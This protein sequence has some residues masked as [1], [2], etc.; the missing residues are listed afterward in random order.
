MSNIDR[1]LRETLRDVAEG[2]PNR[3]A[4][5]IPAVRARAGQLR[6]LRLVSVALPLIM[7]I[8]AATTI[9]AKQFGDTSPVTATP[10]ATHSPSAEPDAKSSGADMTQ[11]PTIEPSGSVQVLTPTSRH[12]ALSWGLAVHP[13]VRGD[14]PLVGTPPR[15]VVECGV[16]VLG[17][18]QSGT[19]ELYAWVKCLEFYDEGAGIRNGVGFSSSA[20]IH[21]TGTGAS[22]SIIKVDFPRQANLKKDIKRLFPPDMHE[23]LIAGHIPVSP[24][25]QQ[26]LEKAKRDLGGGTIYQISPSPAT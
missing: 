23:T 18:S 19:R 9:A 15:T 5:P 26:L 13:D 3:T 14:L 10:A 20:V 22:T 1:V 8:G 21:V 7:G 17:E 25:D 4:D 24:D 11:S 6:R 12:E 2:L 16:R